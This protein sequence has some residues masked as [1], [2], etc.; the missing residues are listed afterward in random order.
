MN[1]AVEMGSG[2]II[3]IQIGSGI[4]K[5]IVGDTKRDRQQSDPI[6][7]LSFFQSEEITLKNP[8][9]WTAC[10]QTRVPPNPRLLFD[11]E[12][13]KIVIRSAAPGLERVSLKMRNNQ[14]L[15][16]A[17]TISFSNLCAQIWETV[18]SALNYK[19]YTVTINYVQ[20]HDLK[21]L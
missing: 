8:V 13:L 4:Q 5:L 21:M 3:N 10:T 9:A 11:P 20:S 6:N 17:F 18:N 15:Q 14:V 7:L 19:A 12:L 1:Y 2:A 16:R